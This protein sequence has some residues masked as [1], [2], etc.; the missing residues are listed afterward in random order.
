LPESGKE[1]TPSIQKINNHLLPATQTHS[2][3]I[4]ERAER[5]IYIIRE[6][7]IERSHHYRKP[8]RYSNANLKYLR[9]YKR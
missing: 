1:I 8:D 4:E 3:N 9:I 7:E 5:C 6:K 2:K